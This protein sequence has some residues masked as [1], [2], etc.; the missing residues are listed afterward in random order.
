MTD[1]TFF[2]SSGKICKTDTTDCRPAYS[3][4]P[5]ETDQTKKNKGPT[6]DGDYTLGEP[7][8]NMRFP[9]IP[10]KSNNMHNRNA[11]QIHGDNGKGNKSASEG[12]IVTDKRDDF[13]KGDRVHVK[14]G[15]DKDGT[16]V[17]S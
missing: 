7:K 6:P 16:C 1:W 9:M 10:D 14:S 11:F 17:L 4:Q 5:G 2:K 3:G 12:C 13:K 8:G 15:D